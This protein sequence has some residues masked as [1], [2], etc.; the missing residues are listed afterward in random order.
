MK[1]SGYFGNG[2]GIMPV[3][4]PGGIT[5]QWGTGRRSLCLLSHFK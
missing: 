2:I 5:L 4:S 1:G 3:N